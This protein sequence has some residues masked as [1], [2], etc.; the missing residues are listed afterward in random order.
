MIE[1]L[2][3]VCGFADHHHLS[4][5]HSVQ[6]GRKVL[7]KRAKGKTIPTLEVAMSVGEHVPRT[8]WDRGMPALVTSSKGNSLILEAAE[9][10]ARDMSVLKKLPFRIFDQ[11]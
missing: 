5:A 7:Y 4:V 9:P 6:D 10:E 11:E 2:R 1:L 8:S 3:A